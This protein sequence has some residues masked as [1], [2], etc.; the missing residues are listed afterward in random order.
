MEVITSVPC[1]EMTDEN[2]HI[3]HM[4]E[5]LSEIHLDLWALRRMA[6]AQL[7]SV[8]LSGGLLAI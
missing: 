8:C 5:G 2:I 4:K 1:V 3:V 6:L 7:T